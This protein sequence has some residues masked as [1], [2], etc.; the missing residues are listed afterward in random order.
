MSKR[1]YRNLGVVLLIL[2]LLVA[3]GIQ[4]T[5]G[6]VASV[7]PVKKVSE[8]KTENFTVT[9][10]SATVSVNGY[11]MLPVMVCFAAGLVCMV[12]SARRKIDG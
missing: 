10:S 11:V 7:G 12:V 4:L 1:F 9:V 6:K 5:T 8:T 2:P 3:V